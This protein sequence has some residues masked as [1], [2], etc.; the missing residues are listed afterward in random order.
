MNLSNAFIHPCSDYSCV[1][2]GTEHER[3]IKRWIEVQNPASKSDDSRVYSSPPLTRL[4]ERVG[5]CRY[6]P[7]S[8]TFKTGRLQQGSDTDEI[9]NEGADL[10]EVKVSV[11]SMQG[12]LEYLMYMFIC[13][14]FDVHHHLTLKHCKISVFLFMLCLYVDIFWVTIN[15]IL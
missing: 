9:D 7:V 5:C 6:C 8:P 15:N 12:F 13:F 10:M 1:P 2:S 3:G 11:W 14:H 4:L